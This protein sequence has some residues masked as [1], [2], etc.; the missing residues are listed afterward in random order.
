MPP[1]EFKEPKGVNPPCAGSNPV[2]RDSSTQQLY[3]RN[4]QARRK[5]KKKD[6]IRIKSFIQLPMGCFLMELPP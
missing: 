5:K 1:I 4:F 3:K 6:K 2:I